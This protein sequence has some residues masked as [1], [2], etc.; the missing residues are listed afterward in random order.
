M[1]LYV[2]FVFFGDKSRLL[3]KTVVRGHRSLIKNKTQTAVMNI[4]SFRISIRD[5]KFIKM[6]KTHNI[7]RRCLCFIF[8]QTFNSSK[9]TLLPR[10][11]TQNNCIMSLQARQQRQI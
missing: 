2:Y 5:V 1:C 3:P 4:V 8:D 10:V 9:D 11:L 7:Y 6:R